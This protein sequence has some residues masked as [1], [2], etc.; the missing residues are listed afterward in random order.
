[1]FPVRVSNS[2]IHARHSDE[3]DLWC[4]CVVCGVRNKVHNHQ[5]KVKDSSPDLGPLRFWVGHALDR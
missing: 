1:M 5:P 3:L 4:L 2:L